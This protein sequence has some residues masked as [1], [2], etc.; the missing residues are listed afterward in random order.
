MI[1]SDGTKRTANNVHADQ[2]LKK[3]CRRSASAKR[4]RSNSAGNSMAAID[5]FQWLINDLFHHPDSEEKKMIE[6]RRE[7][8]F[9]LRSED[10]RQRFVDELIRELKAYAY[11]GSTKK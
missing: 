3:Y 9:S 10:E 1:G 5:T 6:G 4:K 7:Y 8:L 2:S 11:L